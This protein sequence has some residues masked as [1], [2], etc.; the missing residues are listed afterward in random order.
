MQRWAVLV[1]GCAVVATSACSSSVTRP[2]AARLLPD[3][4]RI[5][6]GLTLVGAPALD[7]A[8]GATTPTD[9][10]GEHST[11]WTALFT[12]RGD[13][14][15][16]YRNVAREARRLGL[17]PMRAA[18]EACQLNYRTDP[19]AATP[20]TRSARAADVRCEGSGFVEGVLRSLAVTIVACHTCRPTVS[21][22]EL[23]YE[24][25][26]T[27]PIRR[28]TLR[29]LRPANTRTDRYPTWPVLRGARVIGQADL[30]LCSGSL[31]AVLEVTGSPD[32]VW[33]RY[34]AR[35]TSSTAFERTWAYAATVDG[36][37]VRQALGGKTGQSELVTLVERR[38]L[39][40]PILTV[41]LCSD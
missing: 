17:P 21:A 30:G 25:P 4:V 35:F 33:K 28:R 36:A 29:P 2:T 5:P 15:A 34:R 11:R 1:C 9:P 40:R 6:S 18:R 8:P 3:G 31:Y 32:D 14:V 38:D 7:I 39:A 22:A 12:L 24:H 10:K 16:V 23:D 13:P 19:L 41:T 37:R 20:T 27:R 26:I